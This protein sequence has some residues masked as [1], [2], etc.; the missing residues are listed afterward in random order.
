MVTKQ[1]VALFIMVV[2]AII[3][4]ITFTNIAIYEQSQTY[5]ITVLLS[6]VFEFLDTVAFKLQIEQNA[7]VVAW[8]DEATLEV[9][10]AE[11]ELVF[12]NTYTSSLLNSSGN[13][14]L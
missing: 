6:S 13:A 3:A 5:D 12:W 11:A 7:A 10:Q 2:I 4:V 14:G 8:I 9:Q 1:F